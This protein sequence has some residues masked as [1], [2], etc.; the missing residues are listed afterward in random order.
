MTSLSWLFHA[1]WSL[2]VD[3]RIPRIPNNPEV[4]LAKL[5]HERLSGGCV[6]LLETLRDDVSPMRG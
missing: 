1:F 5:L 4:E 2:R 6:N 3:V